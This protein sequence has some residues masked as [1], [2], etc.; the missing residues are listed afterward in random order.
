MRICS[1]AFVVFGVAAF[2]VELAI[3]DMISPTETAPTIAM[4]MR[5]NVAT[6]GETAFRPL[7][8]KSFL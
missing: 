5:I 6:I 4:M 2:E 8:L 7:Y 1:D 3:P